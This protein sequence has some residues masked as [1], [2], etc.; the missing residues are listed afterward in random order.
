MAGSFQDDDEP[1]SQINVTPLVDVT[2]VLLIIFMVTTPMIM[3][4]SINVNLPKAASSDQSSPGE[5]SVTVTKAGQIFANGKSVSE[6]G[7][8][9]EA[10]KL[11]LSKPDSQAMI[12][13]DKETPY[14]TIVSIVDI[15]KTA[16]IKKF[17]INIQKK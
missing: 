8:K 3:K 16:G 6:E 17:A 10:A 2:L 14:G 11:A 13:G 4:P 5:L 12:S 1:I 7:L 9:A 15:I